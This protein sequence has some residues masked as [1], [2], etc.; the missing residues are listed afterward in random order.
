MKT[1]RNLKKQKRKA[2]GIDY[3][4]N[5]IAIDESPKK[6]IKEDLSDLKNMI[7]N[8]ST[9]KETLINSFEIKIEKP[10]NKIGVDE[11]K[12]KIQIEI[13]K[14]LNNKN[15]IDEKH[16]IENKYEKYY[17]NEKIFLFDEEI[18][19][20]AIDQQKFL[21]DDEK[22]LCD[23]TLD[24]KSILIKSLEIINKHVDNKIKNQDEKFNDLDF[25]NWEKNIS[26]CLLFFIKKLL[27]N[28]HLCPGTFHMVVNI[29][30]VK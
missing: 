24:E 8:L 10:L 9:T 7:E 1:V 5:L 6:K 18:N 23:I 27:I 13:E 21:L 19:K 22:L 30:K 4:N 26:G 15:D 28:V 2:T 16:K 20:E 29:M 17:K 25:K 11:I 3:K 12:N 14:P